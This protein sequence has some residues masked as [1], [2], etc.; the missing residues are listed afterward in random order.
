[1]K[2]RAGAACVLLVTAACA[3]PPGYEEI[4]TTEQIMET[5]VEPMSEKVFDAA[6]WENGVQ[7]GGPKTI[8]DWKNIEA[9]ALMLAESCN[10][11][12]VGSR[13]KD[14]MGWVTRTEAM[15]DAAKEA[16]RAAHARNTDAIF[17]AG[18]KIYQACTQ[19]H[20]QYMPN[21]NAAPPTR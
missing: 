8:D 16:A 17:S 2:A 18:T 5:T 21:L 10:L 15:K 7:V 4:A 11:L 12:L 14:R 9:S 20:Q 1:M 19:C 13:A 3:R 6:V